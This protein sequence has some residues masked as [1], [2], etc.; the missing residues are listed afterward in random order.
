M[1]VFL[2]SNLCHDNCLKHWITDFLL[3]LDIPI[4]C[5]LFKL[6]DDQ[7]I[8]LIVVDFECSVGLAGTGFWRA[9]EILHQLDAG[10]TATNLEV[11]PMSDVYS[12]GMTCYEIV[13]GLMLFEGQPVAV[14]D[15]TLRG[16]RA[17]LPED[18]DQVVKDIIMRYW[19]S[20]PLARPDFNSICARLMIELNLKELD[21]KP[22]YSLSHPPRA[23]CYLS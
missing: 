11:T 19:Q 20:D 3:N 18:L 17:A 10:I 2:P 1:K 13:T 16:E 6:L 14:N 8:N 21:I 15:V 12:Y 9:P 5:S 23:V 7:H 22:E 4:G